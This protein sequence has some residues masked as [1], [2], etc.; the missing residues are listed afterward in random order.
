MRRK[1]RTRIRISA[2]LCATALSGG[3]L[4]GTAQARGTAVATPAAPSCSTPFQGDWLLG[5]ADLPTTRPLGPLLKGY[6]RTG[7]GGPAPD[8]FLKEWR[9]STGKDWRWPGDDG[10]DGPRQVV[11]LKKGTRV[12]RFGLPTGRFLA[13]TDVPYGGRAMP[14][15]SLRTYPGGA[16]CNYHVYKVTKPFGVQEGSIAPWFGQPGKGRQIKLDGAADAGL[17]K[18]VNVKWLLDNHY[19]EELA[20]TRTAAASGL[21]RRVDASGDVD[22]R[23][24]REALRRAGVPDVY[25]RVGGTGDGAASAEFYSLRSRGDGVWVVG[26]SERGREWVVSTYSSADEGARGLYREVVGALGV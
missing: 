2:V 23:T 6:A 3:A 19:L 1:A 13:P 7:A 4:A 18:D 17:P 22:F 11:T 10:F 26:F 8:V 21:V 5:A 12:D 9:D 25:Y 20:T 14:P 15:S 16:V 24:V